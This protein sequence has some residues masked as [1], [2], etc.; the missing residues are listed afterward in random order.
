MIWPTNPGAPSRDRFEFPR[1]GGFTLLELMVVLLI[2]ALLASIAAPQV[3]KHLS[4]AKSE[5][6]KIQVEALTA[7]VNYFQLDLGRYPSD[8][9]GLKAL[10]ERP[11]SDA[12]W[13]GP[14]VERKDSLID[15]WG[16]PYL[17]RHP[18]AHREVE[19]Y[20]LG[21]DG[22]EG[23]EGDASDIGNW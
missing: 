8:Q 10:I 7:A 18:G 9:E 21:S 22:K 13:D 17:Y 23:G 2:L 1:V 19:I 20:T 4:K 14:Y 12:K 16:R 11:A 15:P 3:I 6:A 5:T